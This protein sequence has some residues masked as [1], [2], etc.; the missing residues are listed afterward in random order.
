V[1]GILADINIQKLEI[2]STKSET[3]SKLE[4]RNPKLWRPSVGRG[5]TVGRPGHNRGCGGNGIPLCGSN[6]PF[7]CAFG[8]GDKTMAPAE[9]F[10]VRQW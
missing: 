2:R 8:K 4:I 6:H 1:K 7:S 5:G 9:F 10:G 3:N